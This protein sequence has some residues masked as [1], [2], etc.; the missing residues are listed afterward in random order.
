M[1][2]TTEN[3]TEARSL[4]HI[5][6]NKLK[7]SPKNV[8]KIP[9]SLLH[10]SLPGPTA[11]ALHQQ[12]EANGWRA[13]RYVSNSMHRPAPGNSRTFRKVTNISTHPSVSRRPIPGGVPEEW[14]LQ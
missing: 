7:K 14:W 6:L 11:V 8:R 13:S 4:V 2:A 10:E 12:C 1:I 5:P 3:P 9:H